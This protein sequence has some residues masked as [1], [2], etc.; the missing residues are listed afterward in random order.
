MSFDFT[1]SEDLASILSEGKWAMGHS[2]LVLQKWSSGMS[3]ND[4]FF[5]QAPMWVRLPELPL[6]YWNEDVF[7]GIARTFGELLSMDPITASKHHLNFARICIGVR[8]GIDMPESVALHSKLGVHNQKIIYETIPFACFL[9]LKAGHKAHQCPNE[10]KMKITKLVI[11]DHTKKTTTHTSG[12]GKMKLLWRHKLSVAQGRKTISLK[13][14]T[15]KDTIKKDPPKDK[16]RSSPLKQ[17][18]VLEKTI[19]DP[20]EDPKVQVC[21]PSIALGP[22]VE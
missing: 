15:A 20:L 9:Y 7:G 21:P 8:E 2:S 22:I 11:L 18:P 3:L 12:K 17:G 19:S 13:D 16:A 6:E 14:T 1:Y 5:A 10:A 4:S